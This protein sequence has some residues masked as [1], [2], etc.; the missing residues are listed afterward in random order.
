M[1]E[2]SAGVLDLFRTPNI[3]K[4]SLLLYV[5]WFSVYLAYYGLVLNINS[6]AGDLYVNTIISGASVRDWRCKGTTLCGLSY[7]RPIPSRR[8][9]GGAFDRA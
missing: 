1:S 8:S 6:F 9:C 7:N 4:I 5:I 3:R 2:E